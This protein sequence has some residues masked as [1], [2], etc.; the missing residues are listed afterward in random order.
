[1]LFVPLILLP[2]L[3]GGALAQSTTTL[4]FNPAV[5]SAYACQSSCQ[6]FLADGVRADDATFSP[7]P[8]RNEAF[9]QTPKKFHKSRPGDLLKLE[10]IR[11]LS[12]YAFTNEIPAGTTLYAIQYVSL[13][14]NDTKVPATGFVALPFALADSASDSSPGSKSR[15]PLVSLSHGT[16]GFNPNCAP[17]HS[18]NLYDYFSWTPL[19]L[20]GFAV[21]ATDY[22]GL[23][24][25]YTRHPYI[26]AQINSND[27]YFAAQAA[28]AAFPD[29]LTERWGAVG[30][31]QGGGS[32][33]A[34]TEN[35]LVKDDTNFIGSVAIAPVCR[36]HDQ[37]RLSGIGP[38]PNSGPPPAQAALGYLTLHTWALETAFPAANVTSFLSDTF[39]QRYALAQK[40]HLCLAGASSLTGDL[41]MKELFAP[42]GGEEKWFSQLKKLQDTYGAGL[43]RKAF[44]PL[45][46]VQSEG[47]MAVPW[48]SAELS[49]NTS[50][51][52]GNEV[53]MTLLPLLDHSA[54][55]GATSGVWVPWLKERILQSDTVSKSGSKGCSFKRIRAIDQSAAYAPLDSQ[56]Y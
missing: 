1:M 21:V 56:G 3:T 48:K 6:S 50:C 34:L 20:S 35:E 55:F 42:N 30:H 47:D 53:H 25:N 31:S 49:Y 51:A 7:S 54:T 15:F 27:V 5:A 46:I 29:I 39:A 40:L 32:V 9:Y 13:G 12:S 14:L 17:S 36:I 24:S 41:T 28:Q 52:V 33:Y 45:L 22:A 37:L 11:N 38:S 2:A 16:S 26:A 18:P 43:G 19:L 8:V 44:S 10:P 4:P 23:G